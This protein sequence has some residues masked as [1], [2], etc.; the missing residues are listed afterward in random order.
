MIASFRNDLVLMPSSKIVRKYIFDGQ[1]HALNQDQHLDLKTKICDK[2]KIEFNNVIVVGSGKLGFSIKTAKRYQPFGEE[3][4]IDVAIVSMPLFQKVW[5]GTYRYQQSGAFWPES[6]A[7]F[8]Y[9]SK[10][11]IRPDKLPTSRFF[12]FSALWWDFF[13]DLSASDHHGRV[14]V[15]AGLYC[16]LI[17]LEEYQRICVEECS[18][19]RK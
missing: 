3:S 5:E 19:E 16:S 18:Q 14:R 10:G 8:H 4:D 11:W 6:K 17:F 13:K 1:C 15:R 9:L 2:F 7:F 12:E